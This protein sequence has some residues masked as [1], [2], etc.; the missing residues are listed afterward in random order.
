MAEV[1]KIHTVG[2]YLYPFGY[3]V[4]LP[5][6]QVLNPNYFS[7]FPYPCTPAVPKRIF[8]FNGP[9]VLVIH[10]VSSSFY[11]HFHPLHLSAPL[12]NVQK[13]ISF[14]NLIV[15]QYLKSLSKLPLVTATPLAENVL[16]CFSHD[17]SYFALH[18]QSGS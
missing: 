9:F 16:D 17:C 1:S 11:L 4:R 5:H 2:T 12:A 7:G 3:E 15:I 18:L 13:S 14:C 6:V 8:F 10:F